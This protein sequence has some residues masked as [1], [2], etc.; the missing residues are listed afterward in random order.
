MSKS[1]EDSS[2]PERAALK[3]LEAA[4]SRALER[5]EDL[6]RKLGKAEKRRSEVEKVLKKLADGDD[7]PAE[8]AERLKVLETENADL[9]GRVDHGLAAVERLL[10]Q[11]RFLEEQN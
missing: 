6:T 2:A 7:S 9:R 1:E 10:S 8:M 11:V 3:A 4:V 5:I